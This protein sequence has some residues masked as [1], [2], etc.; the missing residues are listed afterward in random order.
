V[1]YD[2]K[3][4]SDS[5]PAGGADLLYL[6]WRIANAGAKSGGARPISFSEAAAFQ[7]FNPKGWR[8]NFESAPPSRGSNNVQLEH[9][10]SAGVLA[11]AGFHVAG[12]GCRFQPQT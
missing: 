2:R 10:S 3:D 5:S 12:P 8:G 11:R 4:D 6:A 1:G 7:L 9:G